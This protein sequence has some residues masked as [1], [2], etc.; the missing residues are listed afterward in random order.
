MNNTL[1]ELRT[2]I[3]IVLMVLVV[4]ACAGPAQDHGQTELRS[5]YNAAIEDATI[6]ERHEISKNLVAIVPSNNDLVWK[7]NEA[8]QAH[9]LVVTWTDY[10]GYDG[11]V[12]Q[13]TAAGIDIWVTAVPEVQDF[14]KKLTDDP[15]LRLEQVLGLPPQGGYD[16]FVEL[17]VKPA[18]LFRPSADPEISDS[19]AEIDLRIANPFMKLSDRYVRWF[20]DQKKVSYKP[21][22]Y[23]W[24]RLGYTYDWGNPMSHVGLSEFII[25]KGSQIEIKSISS[26]ADYCR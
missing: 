11:K 3:V 5:L 19:E 17:W 12:G 23:P 1:R 8:Q 4:S 26:T 9:V 15:S 16:R 21:D 24:T 14:C 2:N 7:D 20:N 18:D 10:T 22:G 25:T 13:S 6:A